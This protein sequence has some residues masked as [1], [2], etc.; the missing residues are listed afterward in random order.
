MN[1][2]FRTELRQL[3]R[4]AG[5]LA[6][7][8]AG[9][10]IMGVVDMAVI[11]RLGASELGAAGLGNGLFFTISILGMGLVFGVDPMISQAFGAGDPVRARHV[12]WQGIWLS[13][14]VTIVL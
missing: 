4:L 3:L 13:L 5:P 7:A 12:L 9:T 11:G 10:Q 6:A 8:Q 2:P 1:R 14:G